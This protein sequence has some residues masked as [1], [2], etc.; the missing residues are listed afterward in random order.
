MGHRSQ[1]LGLS[2]AWHEDDRS[3]REKEG[4][5]REAQLQW[6]EAG[7]GCARRDLVVVVGGW[8]RSMVAAEGGGSR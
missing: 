2:T 7:E 3:E 8:R 6:W 1:A 4:R 5:T